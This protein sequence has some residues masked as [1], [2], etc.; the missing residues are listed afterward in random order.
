MGF[1]VLFRVDT[2]GR[3][4]RGWSSVADCRIQAWPDWS[5]RFDGSSGFGGSGVSG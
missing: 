5:G 3:Y 2:A 1:I 4:F